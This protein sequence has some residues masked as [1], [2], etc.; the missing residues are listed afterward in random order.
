MVKKTIKVQ[1]VPDSDLIDQNKEV[2][3][4]NQTKKYD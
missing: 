3:Y 1:G 2:N 4:S